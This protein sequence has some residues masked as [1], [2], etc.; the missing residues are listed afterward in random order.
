MKRRLPA[1]AAAMAA[2]LAGPAVGAAGTGADPTRRIDPRPPVV[3]IGFDE[4]PIDAVRAPG[5]SIDA[6]RFPNLA[7]FARDATWWP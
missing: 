7:R 1:I 4:F 3:L 5:G 6:A 2:L